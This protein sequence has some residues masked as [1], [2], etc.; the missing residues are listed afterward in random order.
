[1]ARIS[2]QTLRKPSAIPDEVGEK[3]NHGLTGHS[4]EASEII[5]EPD[6]QLSARLGHV[7]QGIADPD[8]IRP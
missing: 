1:M 5:S 4:K 3:R 6:G 8:L 2:S 7:R